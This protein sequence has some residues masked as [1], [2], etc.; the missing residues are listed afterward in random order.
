MLATFHAMNRDSGTP[1]FDFTAYSIVEQYYD[2]LVA[3][4]SSYAG[5]KG[6]R[7]TRD[8]LDGGDSSNQVW[9]MAPMVGFSLT[10]YEDSGKFYLCMM[11]GSP[12]WPGSN[13]WDCSPGLSGVNPPCRDAVFIAQGNSSAPVGGYPYLGGP[14]PG[15]NGAWPAPYNDPVHNAQYVADVVR[16]LGYVTTTWLGFK[17][18]GIT[19]IDTGDY[20]WVF[21]MDISVRYNYLP[22]NHANLTHQPLGGGKLLIGGSEFNILTDLVEDPTFS[23]PYGATMWASP[24]NRMF[25]AEIASSGNDV[26]APALLQVVKNY[27]DNLRST[28]S[29]MVG[30]GMHINSLITEY[31]EVNLGIDSSKVYRGYFQTTHQIGLVHPI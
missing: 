20:P 8:N 14:Y 27:M 28:G 21:N 3:M 1:S 12:P 9:K 7:P 29:V 15:Y 26:H 16:T 13:G 6:G 19:K 18:C 10:I 11:A 31:E 17:Y 25:R 22:K 5:L 2:E 24:A 23:D 4:E 30:V